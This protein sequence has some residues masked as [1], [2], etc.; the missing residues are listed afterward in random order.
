MKYG[1]TPSPKKKPMASKSAVFQQKSPAP[2]RASPGMVAEAMKS[3]RKPNSKR[4]N[5]I[6]K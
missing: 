1:K 3:A 4:D 6:K 2:T 5:R